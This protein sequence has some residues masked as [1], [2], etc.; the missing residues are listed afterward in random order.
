MCH[1]LLHLLPIAPFSSTTSTPPPPPLP[2]PILLPP[3]SPLVP[4]SSAESLLLV[5]MDSSGRGRSHQWQLG[6]GVM[7]CFASSGKLFLSLSVQNVWWNMLR[8]GNGEAVVIF[9]TVLL[10]IASW[11]LFVIKHPQWHKFSTVPPPK[12]FESTD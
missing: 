2:P 7:F 11:K 4:S 6:G 1:C 10:Q 9:V 8:K 12:L 5:V 3:H